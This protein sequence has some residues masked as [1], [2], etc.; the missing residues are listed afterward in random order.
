MQ[1]MPRFTGVFRLQWFGGLSAQVCVV[2]G[3][4]NKPATRLHFRARNCLENLPELP[5]CVGQRLFCPEFNKLLPHSGLWPPQQAVWRS[6]SDGS[7]SVRRPKR[8]VRFNSPTPA[9]GRMCRPTWT[10]S[11]PQRMAAK[12]HFPTLGTYRFSAWRSIPRLRSSPCLLP[13]SCQEAARHNR[14]GPCASCREPSPLSRARRCLPCE[15]PC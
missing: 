5:H 7:R 6:I 1:R 2:G 13:R 15:R 9:L 10:S 11:E 8:G 4:K 14:P 12:G 3:D